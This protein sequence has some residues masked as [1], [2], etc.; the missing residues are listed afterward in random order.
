MADQMTALALPFYG[1]PLV[2]TPH[3]S[4]L[5]QE[6]I[7]FENVYC[8]SPLCAPSRFSMMAGQLPSRIGAYD[9]AAYFPADIPTMAHYLRV[10]GYSTCLSG[11]MHFVGADQLHGF[12]ERLTTDIYP[13]DFGWTPDWENFAERPSWYHNMLSVV[14]AG[15]C[16]AS[17]QL[18]FDEEVAFQAVRKIYDLAR[19]EEQRPFFLLASFTHPHDPFAITAEYWHRYQ[20]SQIDMPAVPPIPHPDLDP[21]SQRLYHVCALNDYTQ[22]NGRVRNARHAYY[23]MISYIDDKVGQ[24]IQA[25]KNTGLADNTIII[26]V[27]DHGEMLG[28]RGLWYKMSF[29]E[30]SARV[31]LL[32]HAPG[33]F[34]AGHVARPVSLV[35]LLPTV[36]ELADN[37]NGRAV[38]TY[39]S[40][41]D[42]RSLLPLLHNNRDQTS[43]PVYGEMLGE[44]AI[45]PLLM[46]RDGRY[47]Y[48]YSPPDPEQLYDLES[49]PHE[50]HNLAG[51]PEYKQVRQSFY[52]QTTARWD[53]S[54]LH[55]QVLASQRRRRLL[56]AALRH[57]LYTA[58]DFQPAVD[59][60]QMYM[61]NHLDLNVLERTARYPPPEVPQKDGPGVA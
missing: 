47:K 8:N 48:I 9:N 53:I 58:W 38:P 21:H 39:A 12:E 1:H 44:G 42:G 11:K 46:V 5:A 18:D 34:G 25:V 56:D 20:H 7:V 31:P 14:Q 50:L 43:H 33:R 45:A 30:G 22:T 54:R 36:V 28:E 29:F 52:E 59:A 60:S 13:S 4:A 24:L 61:R 35:D 23:G 6:G 32:F 19:R 41:I 3:L 40:P 26:F 10:R 17:N 2:K 37:G 15:L 57:G 16:I 51:Q 49:D 55:Q 27:S